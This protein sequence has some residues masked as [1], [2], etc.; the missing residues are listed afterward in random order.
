MIKD[1]G[2]QFTAGSRTAKD[3]V[4]NLNFNDD[5]V[6]LNSNHPENRNPNWG[7][8][9]VVSAKTDF[10]NESSHP[11]FYQLPVEYFRDPNSLCQLKV[12]CYC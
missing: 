1:E 11:T 3:K 8:R 7:V 6:K 4:P 12:F 10:D 2:E 5:K 9:R